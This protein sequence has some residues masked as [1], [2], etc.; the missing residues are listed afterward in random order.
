MVRDNP[1][2]SLV[3]EIK[4][5]FIALRNG[6]SG[7]WIRAAEPQEASRFA[8]AIPQL[9]QPWA[10]GV[11]PIRLFPAWRRGRCAASGINKSAEGA[12]T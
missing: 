8:N 3:W 5:N 6:C 2:A 9:T 11:L 10:M 1:G 4:S 7:A 12:C